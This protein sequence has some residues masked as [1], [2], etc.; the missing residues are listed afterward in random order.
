VECCYDYYINN[1]TRTPSPLKKENNI[2]L[3]PNCVFVSTPFVFF[4]SHVHFRYF[5]AV[6]INGAIC[7]SWAHKIYRC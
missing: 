6:R 3:P 4:F 7:L 2:F 5:N 1:C